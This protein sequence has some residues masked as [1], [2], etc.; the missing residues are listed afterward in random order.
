MEILPN[1]LL[2]ECFKYFDGLDIFYSFDD[3]NARFSMLICSIPLYIDFNSMT[4]EYFYRTA[5]KI[6][7]NIKI[8]KQIHSL[9]V[10]NQNPFQRQILESEF[11]T[12]GF[13][14]LQS[15]T[16]HHIDETIAEKFIKIVSK[17]PQL[18]AFHMNKLVD[19][20]DE[21]LFQLPMLQFQRLTLPGLYSSEDLLNKFSSIETLKILHCSIPTVHHLFDFTT[22]LKDLHISYLQFNQRSYIP[23]DTQTSST[24]LKYL[25][26]EN[27][28]HNFADIANILK[29]TVD[30]T[31][32]RLIDYQDE[33]IF[34]AN[35][36]QRFI[37]TSLTKLKQ[38]HLTCHYPYHVKHLNIR[39]AYEQLQTDFW[40]KERQWFTECI[41]SKDFSTI[42]TIPYQHNTYTISSQSETYFN[43]TIDH[44]N[45]FTN[46]KHVKL[47][48]DLTKYQ[49]P[50]YFPYVT[51][52]RLGQCYL[53][54]KY[55]QLLKSIV[56]LTNINQLR[57]SVSCNIENSSVLLEILNQSTNLSSLQIDAETLLSLLSDDNPQLCDC[58]SE[59]IKKLT[60]LKT[61]NSENYLNLFQ[62]SWGKSNY[63]DNA[64]EDF[65]QMNKLWQIFEN[66][67]QLECTIEKRHSIQFLL[68]NLPILTCLNVRSRTLN[69][70]TQVLPFANKIAANL[71]LKLVCEFESL[72]DDN[73]SVWIIRET[74]S[75]ISR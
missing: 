45:I 7:S 2:I 23:N 34:D 19:N 73:L 75:V 21:L 47:N 22:N 14:H 32:L 61:D 27:F 39:K 16:L 72:Y 17:L 49:Y 11:S 18:C 30:L 25:T 36:W 56:N 63:I 57:L 69:F 10:T 53:N 54:K 68:E 20:I 51:S 46:V 12:N 64:L 40:L 70:H 8:R 66:V 4:T 59:K 42:Y 5:T 1:E 58:L 6:F 9:K 44:R 29:R 67:Q 43:Q 24:N 13:T 15:L 26:L 33:N 37:C 55:I 71:G 52:I 74:R 28:K 60:L 38:F 50:C 3:L 48:V 41:L 62:Q 35:Q 31:V 65:Y